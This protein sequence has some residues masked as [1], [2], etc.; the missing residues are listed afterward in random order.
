MANRQSND[1]KKTSLDRKNYRSEKVSKKRSK[2]SRCKTSPNAFINFMRDVRKNH[3]G[4]NLSQKEMMVHGGER[5]RNMSDYEK[6]PY[7][8]EANR[9]KSKN[10]KNPLRRPANVHLI[11]KYFVFQSKG[12]RRN[13]EKRNRSRKR[14]LSSVSRSSADSDSSEGNIN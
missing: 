14:D 4:S 11:H 2:T 1:S 5:W 8:E 3:S 7:Y 9:V 13:E 10:N 12:P 6:Q